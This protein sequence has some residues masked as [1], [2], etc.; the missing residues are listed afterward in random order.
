MAEGSILAGQTIPQAEDEGIHTLFEKLAANNPDKTIV[1]C[2]DTKLTVGELN[3]KANMVSR[4]LLETFKDYSLNE[5]PRKDNIV[6]ILMSPSADRVIAILALLKL[7][8]AYL[9]LEAVLPTG[10]IKYII[11]EAKP[12]CIICSEELFPNVNKTDVQAERIRAFIFEKISADIKGMTGGSLAVTDHLVTNDMNTRLAIVLYTSGST[13]VPK[14]VRLTHGNILNRLRW[15]WR[16][17]PYTNEDFG[18]AK[19]SMLFVDSVTEVWGPLLRGVPIVIVPKSVAQNPQIFIETLEKYCVSRLVL[20]PSLLRNMLVYLNMKKDYSKLSKLTYVVCSGETLPIT[21]AKNFF[22]F[23]KDG[24]VLANYY[25]STETTGDVTFEVFRSAADVDRMTFK[26]NLSI[27]KMVDNCTAYLVDEDLRPVALGETGELVVS[28]LNIADGFIDTNHMTNFLTNTL[29]VNKDKYLLKTG[30]FARIIDGR[31]YYEGRKD[32]QVKIRGQRVDTSEIAQVL[33]D[34][35]STEQV[36]VLVHMNKDGDPTIVAFYTT[37][38]AKDMKSELEKVCKDSLPPY[39]VPKFLPLDEIPLLPA[40]GKIDRQALKVMYE[41]SLQ[42]SGSV[43]F[44]DEVTGKVISI[45]A[46]E[47]GLHPSHVDP[48]QNFFDIGGNSVNAIQTL[49]KLSDAGL[50][51]EIGDILS[52]QS[53]D[54]LVRLARCSTL[55]LDDPLEVLERKY[56]IIP[57]GP[58]FTDKK[59]AQHLLALTFADKEVLD[60]SAGVN[61][62]EIMLAIQRGFPPCEKSGI[63]MAVYTK[64]GELVG[65]S[66]AANV[67]DMPSTEEIFAGERLSL[68]GDALMA[69]EKDSCLI[70]ST[71]KSA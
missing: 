18:I 58:G 27:G 45:I 67:K 22:N 64:A 19:T 2:G 57:I 59:A 8:L 60:I 62:A 63:S 66:S 12:L 20:V 15:Q 35:D 70:Y 13:G 56:D 42:A 1:V 11:R 37:K 32:S 41:D 28:G 9:P 46:K 68:L 53:V 49:A 69:G 39:M 16:V 10:R 65:V 33:R 5:L 7:G 61:Y 26:D 52:A 40:T 6:C 14:G 54:E 38:V 48:G 44:A 43:V 47:L 24:H 55:K 30:D 25:G 29:G 23:F 17:F 4:R 50:K 71:T 3:S 21:L 36:V 34:H 31:I 51:I